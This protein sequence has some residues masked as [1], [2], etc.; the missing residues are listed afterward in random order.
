MSA[1]KKNT[2]N[3]NSSVNKTQQNRLMLLSNNA[4]GKKKSTFIKNKERNNIL[5]DY[6]K[7]LVDHILNIVKELKRF[8]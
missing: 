3:K 1:V 8:S 4:V 7:M 5:N 2:A 6:F